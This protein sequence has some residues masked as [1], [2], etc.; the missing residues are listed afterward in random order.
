MA[1]ETAFEPQKLGRLNVASLG[2]FTTRSVSF[3]VALFLGFRAEGPAIL[4]SPAHRP[5]AMGWDVKL[6]LVKGQRL[7]LGNDMRLVQ[8]N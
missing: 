6:E 1:G 4:P 7:E 2:S 3:E 8:S 5:I